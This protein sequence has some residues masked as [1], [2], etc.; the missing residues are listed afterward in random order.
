VIWHFFEVWILFFIVFAVGRTLGA[1]FFSTMALGPLA[2]AQ[3]AVANLIGDGIDG[4]KWRLGVGPDWRAASRSSA[5]WSPAPSPSPNLPEEDALE[6]APEPIPEPD[7]Q[8]ETEDIDVAG[9]E[10]IE[11]VLDAIE[12]RESLSDLSTTGENARMR[13]A[14]LARPRSSV[15]DNLQR[16]RGIGKRNEEILFRLGV[17]HFGQIAAWTPAEARWIGTHISFPERIERDDWVGQAM[18]LASG[19]DPE[20]ILSKEREKDG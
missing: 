12:A 4:V 9:G 8:V 1:F 13:P 18:I 10:K 15:P 19:G 16:I 6:V 3:G 5:A 14:W 17:F 7:D 20:K 2:G 11:D